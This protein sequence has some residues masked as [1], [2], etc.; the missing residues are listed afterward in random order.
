M[1]L[2]GAGLSASASNETLGTMIDGVTSKAGVTIAVLEE[3]RKLKMNELMLKGVTTGKKR[4]D[5]I[6]ES[7]HPH[8]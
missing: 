5:E 1:V 4:S 6:K 8:N 2:F 7:L 3:W